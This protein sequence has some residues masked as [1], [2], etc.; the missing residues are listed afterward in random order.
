MDTK[1]LIYFRPKEAPAPI[2]TT[3][4]NDAWLDNLL[5]CNRVME[6]LSPGNQI[7]GAISSELTQ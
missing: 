7:Q 4:E 5:N 2:Y 3:I 1:K 6:I